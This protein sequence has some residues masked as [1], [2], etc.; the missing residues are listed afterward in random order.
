MSV[1]KV[2]IV[3]RPNVGKSSL[4]NWLAQKRISVVEP[5]A[6]VTRDRVIFL[7]HVDDRYFELVDTVGI[8][9][10]DKDD[11]SEDIERQIAVGI[12]EAA[13]ILFVVDVAAGLVPL[14]VQ[15]A[16]RLR[17]VSKPMLLVVNKCDSPKQERE[18]AE[19]HKLTNAP[20]ITTSV[21]AERHREE[22]LDAIIEH[23]PAHEELEREEGQL[24]QV[25]PE[26]KLAIVGRRN[27]GKST[28]INA[29]A[30]T[31]RMIVSEIPGTTRDSVDVRFEL[32]GKAF[33]A[34]DTPGVRKRKS[35]ANDIEYYGLLR[36]KRSIRRADVVFMFFDAQETISAVD[37]QLVNEIAEH[38]KP[39][40][41]VINK[42]DTAAEKELTMEGW[43][44]YLMETFAMMRH[45]PLAYITAKEERNVKKLI[46]LAQTI[47]K[48]ARLRVSTARLNAVVR[49]AVLRNRPPVRVNKQ[50]KIFFATQVATAPPTIVLKCNY[51]KSIDQ[52]WQRY[53]LGVLRE[54][55]PFQEV[56]IKVYFRSRDRGGGSGRSLD[57]LP[58]LD[59]ALVADEEVADD[60]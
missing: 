34:I 6:G 41:F 37:K 42:W 45:V 48:Q 18:T 20:L 31:E 8:G 32:D 60:I 49:A 10:V 27:V 21:I 55:L 33:I 23:L 2:V 3:G 44:K 38:Y 13:L 5:T 28:F 47:A 16:E 40:I 15:V 39:C 4:L 58:D 50:P 29:L 12:D 35:L 53:L 59:P 1:P 46:N 14:D 11:L 9:I 43:T 57:E 22:L 56:P 7:M 26:L 52:T 54:N 36:A 25:E 51:P 17:G 24:L 30:Q 19:F